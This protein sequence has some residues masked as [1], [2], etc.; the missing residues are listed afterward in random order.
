MAV[1]YS[2]IPVPIYLST[3]IFLFLFPPPLHSVCPRYLYVPFLHREQIAANRKPKA[4]QEKASSNVGTRHKRSVL[5]PEKRTSGRNASVATTSISTEVVVPTLS[6]LAAPAVIADEEGSILIGKLCDFKTPVG[7]QVTFHAILSPGEKVPR[8]MGVTDVTTTAISN[9][10]G[11][12][13]VA[14]NSTS[15]GSNGHSGAATVL[16]A[17]TINSTDINDPSTS[18]MLKEIHP[19]SDKHSLPLENTQSISLSLPLTSSL[20]V[21][22]NSTNSTVTTVPS[23]NVTTSNSLGCKVAGKGSVPI[24]NINLP[25]SGFF[26]LDEYDIRT[27][28]EALPNSEQCVNYHFSTA[29]E[30]RDQLISGC[31]ADLYRIVEKKSIDERMVSLIL[32]ERKH[33]ESCKSLLY[34]QMRGPYVH[35]KQV[36]TASNLNPT[37]VPVP[38]TSTGPGSV[39]TMQGV[40]AM[41]NETLVTLPL[42]LS[43][44]SSIIT[45]P[46]SIPFSAAAT[47]DQA[48]SAYAIS[49]CKTD[50]SPLFPAKFSTK[51]GE[52][53]IALW[54]FLD[55][56]RTLT[57]DLSFSFGDIVQCIPKPES[58]VPT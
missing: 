23:T 16:G 1:I 12:L 3:L 21:S 14:V 52:M 34:T 25:L 41:N 7:Y 57:G 20:P 22:A 24:T 8:K 6:T 38:G 27:C 45:L 11:N 40:D 54:D 43:S 58:N 19:H 55:Y 36:N 10:V 18:L 49:S 37:P 5:T 31:K 39:D 17:P 35:P 32:K 4:R 44:S 13:N 2:P 9:E 28:L 33:W 42:P 47:V 50:F 51:E 48:T 53:A 46:S 56:S 30:I 26:G 15:G 29:S